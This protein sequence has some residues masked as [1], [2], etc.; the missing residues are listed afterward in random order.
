MAGKVLVIIASGQEAKEKALT[1]IMY[2]VNAKKY[3]WLEDVRIMF[4]GPSEKLML[5][6]DPE[7]ERSM[8]SIRKV[9]LIPMACKAIARDEDI[10]PKL[11]KLGI[12]VEFVGNIIS[13]LIREGYA[14]MVF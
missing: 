10:E 1:G 2:A 4:F 6:E 5:S 7:V 3:N 13:G 9:G 8:E 14:T 12:G 11:V